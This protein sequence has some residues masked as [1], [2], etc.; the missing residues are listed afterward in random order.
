ML[1]DVFAE[2]QRRY[3]VKRERNLVLDRALSRRKG[4]GFHPIYV[5]I[6]ECQVL[7]AAGKGSD[8][9]KI[10]GTTDD[11]RAWK[12]VKKLHDQARA[13]NIHIMQATQRPDNRTLPVQVREGA[14]V[15]AALY[16]PNA[17]TARMVLA[18]AADR[19][20]RPQDL[21]SGKDRGTVVL[22]GD[23]E[24]IPT[25]MAFTIVKSH[26]FDGDEAASVIER[27][28]AIR[29]R[30]GIAAETPAEDAPVEVDELADIARVMDG[31]EQTGTPVI[32][33]RLGELGEHYAGW[34]SRRLSVVLRDAGIEVRKS[35]G[36]K[37][38]KAADVE[39][40]IARRERAR[41]HVVRDGG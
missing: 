39:A 19:G 31:E 27:A 18:D 14:H 24:D 5:W 2:M 7:Y 30:Y 10:G 1:D 23:V 8:K 28:I 36:K 41:L 26:G 22:T 37:V 34:E 4:S 11:A 13:V 3:T 25:G 33:Q 32:L 9:R 35:H 29:E 20:A 38:V 21:R 16:V 15:R 17:D 6:D 12:V 40:A